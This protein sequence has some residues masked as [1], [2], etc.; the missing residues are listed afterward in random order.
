M[1]LEITLIDINVS[2]ITSLIDIVLFEINTM[3][4][5]SVGNKYRIFIEVFEKKICI[6]TI[7]FEI[8]AKSKRPY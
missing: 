6:E 4:K 1:L 2:E 5:K 3:L 7:M 8:N